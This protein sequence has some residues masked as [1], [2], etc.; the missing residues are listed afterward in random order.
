MEPDANKEVTVINIK[1]VGENLFLLLYTDYKE[2]KYT[3]LIDNIP[4][5]YG[6]YKYIRPTFLHLYQPDRDSGIILC[7]Y[8]ATLDH[9]GIIITLPLKWKIS[10]VVNIEIPAADKSVQASMIYDK[11]E[12]IP[13]L[14]KPT[15]DIQVPKK[16]LFPWWPF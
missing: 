15:E 9:Y 16:P 10:F 3:I 4:M 1:G 13:T 8:D 2:T 6:R 11:L 14:E 12:E 7:N 5:A